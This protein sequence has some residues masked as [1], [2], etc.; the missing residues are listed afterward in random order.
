MPKISLIVCVHG[1]REF[2]AR[3]LSRSGD[4]YD[5]LLVIHDGPDL[6]DVK[7]VVEQYRGKFIERPSAYS[8][9]PH[10]P[11]AIGEARHDWIL[12]FDSDE[13]PSP[14][15]KDWLIRF[16]NV[17]EPDTAVAGYYC[18]WPAWNG[19]RS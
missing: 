9:E 10:L 6:E 13:Y 3:L 16:R 7:S 8:Q 2:L 1:D 11:F 17:T 19:R 15:L 5:E 12:R 14:E 4:C 18:V